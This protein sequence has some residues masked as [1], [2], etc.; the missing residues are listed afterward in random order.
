MAARNR[1][2]SS[3]GVASSRSLSTDWASCVPE[4]P[5]HRSQGQRT[6]RR[7]HSELSARGGLERKG[8][9]S[10]LRSSSISG[11]P[12]ADAAS[13]AIAS[14]A[15]HTESC[16]PLARRAGSTAAVHFVTRHAEHSIRTRTCSSSSAASGAPA[17]SSTARTASIIAS[18]ART[19]APPDRL[20]ALRL[21]L[22]R[23]NSDDLPDHG[24]GDLAREDRRA[25]SRQLAEHPPRAGPFADRSGSDPDPLAAPVAERAEAE[26]LVGTASHDDLG[27]CAE[28]RP[29]R[30]PRPNQ[31]PQPSIGVAAAQ[32]DEG[33]A[34]RAANR[35]NPRL[36]RSCRNGRTRA[37]CSCAHRSSWERRGEIRSLA[38]DSRRAVCHIRS[39]RQEKPLMD[40]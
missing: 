15:S 25:Q 2:S 31:L 9:D 38:E 1:R 7:P 20:E 32:E 21:V 19:A 18:T 36:E 30:R 4:G 37:E 13:A 6:A 12:R 16:S 34:R 28:A 11:A 3:R 17:G 33:H 8:N 29:H 23:R 10:S 35:R 24:P 5:S 14:A 22:G 27:Q 26:L 39:L 40:T